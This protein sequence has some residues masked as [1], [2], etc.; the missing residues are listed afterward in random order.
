[1]LTHSKNNYMNISFQ[2]LRKIKHAL[3]TGSVSKIA[4]ELKIEEQ[5]VRN[6]FGAQKYAKGEIVDAHVRPGPH[7][8]VVALENTKI[9]DLAKQI[10][11]ASKN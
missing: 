3:P 2:D 4:S 11:K 8:G 7:G 1:M 6:Y 9:L 10:I 5:T